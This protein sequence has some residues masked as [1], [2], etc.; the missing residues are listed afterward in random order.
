MLKLKLTAVAP[1]EPPKSLD[2]EELAF[3]EE[4]KVKE[5]EKEAI[6]KKNESDELAAFGKAFMQNIARCSKN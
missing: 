5:Q 6:Q 3:L 4:Q 2:N 1:P